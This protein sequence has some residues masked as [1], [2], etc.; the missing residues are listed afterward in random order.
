MQFYIVIE[1]TLKKEKFFSAITVT[2]VEQVL[3]HFLLLA[4]CFLTSL[5]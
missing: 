1:I 5:S 4:V 3:E 2:S